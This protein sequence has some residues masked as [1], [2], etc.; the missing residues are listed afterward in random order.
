VLKDA[1]INLGVF[2]GNQETPEERSTPLNEFIRIYGDT[3][4]MMHVVDVDS[5]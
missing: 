5:T 4:S 3:N 1:I 2:G